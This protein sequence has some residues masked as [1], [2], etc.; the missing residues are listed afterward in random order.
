[1]RANFLLRYLAFKQLVEGDANRI[2]QISA[3]RRWGIT[4]NGEDELI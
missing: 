4:V 1:M 3:L 2:V